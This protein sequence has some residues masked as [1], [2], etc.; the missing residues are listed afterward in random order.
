[1]NILL[2]YPTSLDEAGRPKKYQKAFL[3]PLSLAVLARLIPER[4]SVKVVNDIVETIDFSADYDLVAITAMTTHIPR[5][6]QIADQ[7][8]ELGVSVVIGGVHVS[9]L[10]D[11]ASNHADAV[12]VG[13]AEILWPEILQDA[14]NNRLR[15]IYR[16]DELFEMTEA[17]IPKWDAMNM[18]IYPRRLGSKWPMMPIFTTR[19]CPYNCKFCAVTKFAGNC[20]RVRS[21][22]AVQSEI[23]ASQARELFFVDDNI[24]GHADYSR[25]LFQMV[26]KEKVR[27]MSQIST[28][29]LNTPDI[30]D[31]AAES[32]CFYFFVGV[33][34]L[35]KKSLNSVNKG[36][37]NVDAYEELVAR[38][39]R[40]GVVPFLSFMFGFDDD[41]EDQ[42]ELTMDFVRRNKIG[43]AAF[44]ILTPLPGT[45]FYHEIKQAAR[46]ENSDWSLYDGTQALFRPVCGTRESLQ[47]KYWK[48]YKEMYRLPNLVRNIVWNTRA[49]RA[50]VSELFRNLLYQPIFRSK[51]AI[52]EHPFSGGI[53]RCQ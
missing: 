3:P 38:M 46:I 35:N 9:M 17:V 30:I 41:L 53:L 1:M 4:H 40:A 45:D 10:P 31:L 2:I 33:E 5:A 11:E 42:F 32:G 48:T 16:Q 34:S 47:R 50:P 52:H 12:M 18:G 44:W 28:R 7:F 36:F 37:N 23:Q 29:V 19:G 8:R 43:F 20:F 25:E 39:K 13:E 6:Y 24:G 51:V 22:A 14:E 26:K 27:W 15:K 49:S 21:I